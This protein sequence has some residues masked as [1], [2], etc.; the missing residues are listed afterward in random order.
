MNVGS[1]WTVGEDKITRTLEFSSFK[2]AIG[3]VNKVAEAAEQMDHH[4]DIRVH[5]YKKVDIEL[6]TH[7]AGGVTKKDYELAKEIDMLV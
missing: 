6:T 4:P 3:F 7:D 2:E 5:S 1:E